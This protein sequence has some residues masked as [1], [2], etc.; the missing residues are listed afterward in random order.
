MKRIAYLTLILAAMPLYAGKNQN[1]SDMHSL[2]RW[3]SSA[4][5][6][7]DYQQWAP[8]AA[9]LADL[10]AQGYGSIPL[11]ESH[12][13]RILPDYDT[14]E[15]ITTSRLFLTSEGIANDG[16]IGFWL[17]TTFQH[18]EILDAYVLQADG[19]RTEF[20]RNTLQI[21]TDNGNNLFTDD[22]F[23]TLPFSHL[24][25]GCLTVLRYTIVSERNKRLMPW[26]RHFYPLRF[27][28]LE[29]FQVTIDWT[30]PALKPVWQT[31]FAGLNC[32]ESANSLSCTSRKAIAPI[33]LDPD[34]PAALDILP[35]LAITEPGSWAA[36][37][38]RMAQIADSSLSTSGKMADLAKQITAGSNHPRESFKRLS[39]FVSREIRYVGIEQGQGGIKPRP[40]ETTL[41]RRYGDCKDKTML[42]VD[43]ARQAGLDAYPVLTS[44]VRKSLD[45]LILPSA[46]YFNHMLACVNFKDKQEY[47]VDLT[48]PDTVGEYV[49]ANLQGAVALS[50]GRN[51]QAPHNL[52]TETYTWVE[53]IHAD[54]QLSKDGEIVESLER[55]FGSQWAADLRSMLVLKN[56]MERQRWLENSYHAVMGDKLMPEIQLQGLDRPGET[57]AIRSETRF[58]NAFDPDTL[59]HYREPELWLRSLSADL[60]TNNKHYPYSFQGIDYQ[61][62]IS[63]RIPPGRSIENV[64]P[65]IDFNSQWGSFKRHY[66][67]QGNRVTAYTEL[68]MPKA[69]IP[70]EQIKGFNSFLD[71]VGEQNRIDFS[72]HNFQSD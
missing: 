16:N 30:A 59:R 45:K 6:P 52:A 50:I 55:R 61:S 19:S 26:S 13:I 40:T 70:L 68:K 60:K 32:H 31:D 29:T 43:L 63:Y 10:S 28:P 35:T 14:E 1:P 57:L 33:P 3:H 72:V 53:R 2:V 11:T 23:V 22:V 41:E 64:G 48:D 58:P 51:T 18:A 42:F 34:M 49:S 36:I 69:T 56:R 46:A 62:D 39:R 15:T 44:T 9:R 17:N 7:A 47:C 65:R 20:D 12:Q 38:E 66:R 25:P 4:S 71:I 67:Q 54:N 21:N 5:K 27:E 24:K 37:S 8:S